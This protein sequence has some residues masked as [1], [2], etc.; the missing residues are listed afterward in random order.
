MI[1]GALCYAL[2]PE[3]A[4]RSRSMPFFAGSAQGG[5]VKPGGLVGLANPRDGLT[6]P[7]LFQGLI[8]DTPDGLQSRKVLVAE[9]DA[10]V[11][12]HEAARAEPPAA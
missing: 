5:G 6:L 1:P 3:H 8:F 9:G 10:T 7:D 4:S 11:G 12:Q 2:L